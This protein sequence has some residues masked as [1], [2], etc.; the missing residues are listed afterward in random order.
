MATTEENEIIERILDG[1]RD[2]YAILIN[3]YKQPVFNL[4]FRMTASLEDADDL[5]QEIFARAFTRLRLFNKEKS[6]FTWLYT[7]SLNVIR[8]YLRKKEWDSLAVSDFSD[9]DKHL[10]NTADCGLDPEQITA[11]NQLRK[12]LESCLLKLTLDLREALVLRFY[13]GLSFE[14]IAGITGRSI[15]A[16]KM[17]VYRG[18]EEL[19]RMMNGKIL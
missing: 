1:E 15:S 4:A 7:I 14:D 11:D 17:R 13:Q 18:I 8:N 5:S 6:F 10:L 12:L 2:L 3:R 9:K 16:M 19:Q